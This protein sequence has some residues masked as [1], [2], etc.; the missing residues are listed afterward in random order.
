MTKII[1]LTG[2]IGSGKSTVANLFM[3]KGVPVYIADT[4]AKKLMESRNIITKITNYFGNDILVNLKI[5]RPKLA[6]LVFNNPEKLSELNNIVH[7]EVQ[8]HFQNWL[9]NKKDFPFVIKEAAILFETGGNKQCD[10]VITVVAPQELRI[11]RVKERDKVTRED[12]LE[13]INNQ[14][15]D[16]MKISASDFVIE[17]IDFENT[18]T[19]V[20]Q[21]LKVLNNL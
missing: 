17:N 14:W 6:K 19:K 10:K 7:P 18:K 21:I 1:G 15:T 4:E 8:K 20:N 3:S 12:V 9:K 5:D 11:Q 16:E 2:G 13:R